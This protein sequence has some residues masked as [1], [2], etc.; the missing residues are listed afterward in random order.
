MLRHCA[1]SLGR[2]GALTIE[3]LAPGVRD[4]LELHAPRGQEGDPALALAR[5]AA[6]GGITE[7]LDTLG[8]QIVHRGVDVVDV[9]GDMMPAVIAVPRHGQGL[10]GRGVL[11]DLEY[12]LSAAAEEMQLLHRKS[13]GDGKR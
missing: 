3:G 7:D 9:E 13:L 11:E 5:P 1:P 4:E 8:A 12:R 2:T 6:R 10:V